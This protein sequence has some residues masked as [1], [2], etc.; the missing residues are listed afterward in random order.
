MGQQ[1]NR[2]MINGFGR[3]GRIL[4]RQILTEETIEVVAINDLMEDLENLTYLYNYDSHYGQSCLRAYAKAESNTIEID[5]KSIK[6]LSS[7]NLSDLPFEDLGIDMIIDATGVHQNIVD[8]RDLIAK[9]K[10]KK[11]IITHA[12][13]DDFDIHIIMGANDDALDMKNHN[14]IAA[15]ICDANAI[16]HP[17]ATLEKE[18]GI[19]SGFVTTLHPWLSYQN[20]VDGPLVSQADPAHFWKDYSL[21]RSS[22]GAFI[23]K[24]TTAVKALDFVLPEISK[25]IV[26]FSYRLPTHVVCSADMTLTLKA[27][28]TPDDVHRVLKEIYKNSPYVKFNEE[29]LIS[30]DYESCEA[31]C[32]IDTQWTSVANGNL[33]KL[34][35]WYDNEW[36]Y[37]ARV[38]DLV[39][40]II[41]SNLS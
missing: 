38:K 34:V 37:S 3:I 17:I 28:V 21:G 1:H 2:V 40:K 39:K 36:G 9:D 20:L 12:P 15:S 16:V 5:G 10:F 4:L 33:L 22:V 18:F 13:K 6:V 29:S 31:S 32:V 11:L 7:P 8:S 26:G 27:N 19:E 35:C 25:K 41:K 14:V 24:D 23:P 30:K